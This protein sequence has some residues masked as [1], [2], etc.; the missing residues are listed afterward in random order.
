MGFGKR[1]QTLFEIASQ[2]PWLLLVLA[3]LPLVLAAFWLRIYPTRRWVAMIGISVVLSV[4]VVF[5]PSLL[6]ILGLFDGLVIAVTAIDGLLLVI[7]TRKMLGDGLTI[8]RTVSRT[9]SLGVPLDCSLILR[10]H[11]QLRMRGDIR[12]DVPEYF[13]SEPTQHNLDLPPR[14]QLQLRRKLTPHRR[15][16]FKLDRVDLKLF[17]PL[18]LWQR[19]I[20]RSLHSQLNVFPDM[21]QLSDY[22]LLARTDRLSLIGVRRTRRIGQDSDFERLRDYTRDDNYRHIDWRS[23]ARRNKLTVRQFQSDQSQRLIFLLDCG[24]MMTNQRNGY[25]LLDHALN[26][27]LMMSYVA[28]H[29][30]DSVGMICFS[31]TI[32]AY[33][34]PRGGASQMNRLLQAGFD[35]F[36][37]MVESRYDQAFL[38]LNSHCKRRSLVTLTTNIVDEVNAEVV[39]DHLSNLTGTH[40][41]L[42]VVLRDREMFDAADYPAEVLQTTN[43]QIA[44]TSLDETK[45]Y[46]AAAAAEMLVWREEVLSGLRHKGVL[47]VDAFPDELSAPMV[48]QYL[49]VKAQHLL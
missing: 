30:G 47:V 6:V 16:A 45:T 15:G 41:P 22:A 11:T 7:T 10:N 35:Q 18:G 21:K 8:E 20:N 46:R 28:L 1:F 2:W 9:S 14:L 42:A 17:S 33:L 40:L 29:Q 36:P 32:H 39:S 31:D 38:Y 23:T 13:V 34:P 5:F 44:T 3:S 48:N 27:I 24:R 26:S 43:G 25:S 49:Q 12:D 4:A 19:H 37:R